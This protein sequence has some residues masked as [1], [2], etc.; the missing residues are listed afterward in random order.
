MHTAAYGRSGKQGNPQ[1]TK[2]RPLLRPRFFQKRESGG[3][4]MV[5]GVRN[6]TITPTIRFELALVEIAAEQ[7]GAGLQAAGLGGL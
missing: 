5:A 1:T 7:L 4:K 3:Q 2:I 6:H